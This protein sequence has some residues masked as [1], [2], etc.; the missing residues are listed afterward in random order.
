MPSPESKQKRYHRTFTSKDEAK[1]FVSEF[2]PEWAEQHVGFDL[3][4]SSLY[5]RQIERVNYYMNADP[6]SFKR[7]VDALEALALPYIDEYYLKEMKILSI[8][9]NNLIRKLKSKYLKIPRKVLAQIDF[10]VATYKFDN[11]SLLFD[12]IGLYPLKHGTLILDHDRYI[13]LRNALRMIAGTDPEGV[14][15]VQQEID[16]T[17][18]VEQDEFVKAFSE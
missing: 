4:I 2:R 3:D 7:N 14:Q 6:S 13:P 10:Q 5:F 9:N 17:P 8:Y 18:P 15:Q 11:L 16:D 1:Q 12:R